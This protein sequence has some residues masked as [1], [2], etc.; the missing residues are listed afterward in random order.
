M[1]KAWKKLHLIMVLSVLL[2]AVAGCQNSTSSE[3][4]NNASQSEDSAQNKD[5]SQNGD[6]AENE[7][8]SQDDSSGEDGNSGSEDAQNLDYAA[9]ADELKDLVTD[10]TMNEMQSEMIE[11]TYGISPDILEGAKVYLSSASTANEVAVFS[12]KEEKDVQSVMDILGERVS[13]REASYKEYDAKEAEKL[14]NSI[15]GSK[16]R[17]VIL[18]VV[19]DIDAAKEILNKY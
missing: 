7:D 12:C 8:G 4:E 9:L 14:K 16:G 19:E 11:A 2:L 17:C 6:G 5:S 10:D 3:T 13:S 18:I 15:I 1:Q